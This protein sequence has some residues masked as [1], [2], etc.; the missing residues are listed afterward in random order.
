MGCIKMHMSKVH[1]WVGINRDDT[2]VFEKYFELDYSDQDIDIDDPNYNVCQFCNDIGERRYD[3]DLIGVCR[4]DELRNITEFLEELS[5]SSE[6]GIEIQDT[7][8][9]KGFESINSMFYYMDPKL[10]ISDVHKLY[11]KLTY[12]GVFE[13]EL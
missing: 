3:E 12:L 6:I 8:L 9:E 7:S 1:I 5:V 2:Y 10:E 13:T 11:N 4:T